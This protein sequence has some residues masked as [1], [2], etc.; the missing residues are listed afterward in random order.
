LY[1][2]TGRMSWT[3]QDAIYTR[4]ANTYKD[5]DGEM[6]V[7]DYLQWLLTEATNEE[8]FPELYQ[9]GDAITKADRD[10]YTNYLNL[11]H[12][13]LLNGLQEIVRKCCDSKV[14]SAEEFD[15]TY[16]DMIFKSGTVFSTAAR[17][18]CIVRRIMDWSPPVDEIDVPDTTP[19]EPTEVDEE[20]YPVSDD[21]ESDVNFKVTGPL[22]RQATQFKYQTMTDLKRNYDV[23]GQTT[24][25]NVDNLIH[26]MA[27]LKPGRYLELP[28]EGE[29]LTGDLQEE[30]ASRYR[31]EIALRKFYLASLKQ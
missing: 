4:K 13:S 1:T 14:C 23:T 31:V 9:S 21:D 19:M 5:G 15:T 27:I 29:L 24:C 18:I 16:D 20:R 8:V 22:S 3:F 30:L 7:D 6:L 10:Q 11:E 28:W 26:N 12:A 25:L 2:R 17:S